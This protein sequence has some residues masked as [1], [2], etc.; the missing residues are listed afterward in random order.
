MEFI[1]D[2]SNGVI[3]NYLVANEGGK[4]RMV[5]WSPRHRNYISEKENALFFNNFY[6]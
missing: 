3:H 6:I 4:V 2:E 1:L 5:Y